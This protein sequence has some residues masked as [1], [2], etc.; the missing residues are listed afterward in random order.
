MIELDFT[1]INSE[2]D[3]HDYLEKKL[4]L[5]GYYGRNLD[6]LW[7]VLSERTDEYIIRGRMDLVRSLGEYGQNV[8]DVFDELGTA[9]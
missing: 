8:L 4:G 6:A 1:N 9:E 5:P 2:P 3:L 7:D